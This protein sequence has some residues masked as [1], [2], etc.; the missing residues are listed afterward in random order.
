MAPTKLTLKFKPLV[1]DAVTKYRQALNFLLILLIFVSPFTFAHAPEFEAHGHWHFL[2]RE[3]AFE[4]VGRIYAS[5]A[6]PDL[7]NCSGVLISPRQVLTAYH[8]IASVEGLAK[9]VRFVAD[10]GEE[11]VV[12]RWRWEETGRVPKLLDHYMNEKDKV[13]AAQEELVLLELVDEIKHVR[14]VKVLRLDESAKLNLDST[15]L[16]VGFPYAKT[17]GLTRPEKYKTLLGFRTS[18]E[19]L[20]QWHGVAMSG[21]S[22]GGVFTSF[23]GEVALVG[24][25]VAASPKAGVTTVLMP[26]RYPN[27]AREIS[28]RN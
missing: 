23:E 27:L 8:C 28:L 25:N 13:A 5:F 20:T 7:P 26:P 9:Q 1:S 10:S 4:S 18:H 24:I 21:Y 22:G 6:P 14:P 3:K 2:A 15:F 19:K 17:Y 12:A 11:S 16:S